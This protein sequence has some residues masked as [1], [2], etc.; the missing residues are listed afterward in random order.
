MSNTR[1]FSRLRYE[2]MQEL[3]E[4]FQKDNITCGFMREAEYNSETNQIKGFCYFMADQGVTARCK[5]Y[6][7]FNTDGCKYYEKWRDSKL[8]SLS[9]TRQTS[10]AQQDKNKTKQEIKE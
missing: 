9:N 7:P 10:I 6:L 5:K 2:G 3:Q 8:E 1:E 4:R